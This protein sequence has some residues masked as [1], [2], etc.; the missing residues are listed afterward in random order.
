ML[1]LKLSAARLSNC[2]ISVANLGSRVIDPVW[3][4]KCDIHLPFHTGSITRLPRF[5][6]LMS[7]LLSLAALGNYTACNPHMLVLTSRVGLEWDWVSC[8]CSI[9]VGS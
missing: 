3:N 7:Q 8:P 4:G 6:T 2:D 1:K 9:L 5:A